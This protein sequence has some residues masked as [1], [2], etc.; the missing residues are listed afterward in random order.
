[1]LRQ[2]AGMLSRIRAKLVVAAIGASSLATTGCSSE[3]D[4]TATACTPSGPGTID[5]GPCDPDPLRTNLP[6]LWN[7]NSVD[8]YDCPILQSTAEHNEPDAMIFKAIIYVESRFQYDAVGC[9]DNGPCCPEVGWTAAEC[10]CLGMMQNGPECG[11]TSGPGLRSDGH[12]NMETDPDCAE[13]TNSVFNPVVNIEIGIA[14]VSRNRARMMEDFP[15]CTEDQYTMM[16]IGEYNN[17]Q[18]TQSCTVYNFSYDSA[19]LQAYHEYS[20]AAGWPAHP[21]VA[22]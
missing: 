16:A 10:A 13:F 4:Q 3:R 11:A 22:E 2:D 8:A 14:R 17:Y 18:S 21:Y 7:G 5:P 9:T 15:G 20:A 19:V 12:P 6:P 1:M